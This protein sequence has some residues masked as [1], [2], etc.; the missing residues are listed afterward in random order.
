M[1]PTQQAPLCPLMQMRK[2][3]LRGEDF[4]AQQ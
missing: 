4:T 1:E 2:L 3:R